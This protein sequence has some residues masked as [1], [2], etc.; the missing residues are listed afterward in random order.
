MIVVRAAVGVGD[1]GAPESA[2]VVGGGR[3]E[4]GCLRDGLLGERR[5]IL[6][7]LPPSVDARWPAALAIG[8]AAAAF[9]GLAVWFGVG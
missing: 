5:L 7:R 8:V 6:T 9:A 1:G 2:A 3:G 4:P